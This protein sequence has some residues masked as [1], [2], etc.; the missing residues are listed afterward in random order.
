MTRRAPALRV[1]YSTKVHVTKQGGQQ[2][3]N[4]TSEFWTMWKILYNCWSLVPC[5][6]DQKI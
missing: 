2:I 3:D 6:S 4:L 1:N 5:S